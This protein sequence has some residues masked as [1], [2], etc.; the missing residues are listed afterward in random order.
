MNTQDWEDTQIHAYVDGELEAAMAQRLEADSRADA[1]LAARVARQQ[2]VRQLLR[3]QFDPVL[4][5]TVP[6]PLRA[7]A[8]RGSARSE[9]P[10]AEVIPLAAHRRPE[11]APRAAWSAREW[12]AIAATLLLGTLLG[13]TLFGTSGNLP[14]ETEQGRLV[15]SGALETA[16]STQLS[17]TAP[18]GAAQ[19]GLTFRASD[20]AWCRT[21]GLPQ[22]PAG[23]A[24][25]R[26]GHWAVQL[27][28]DSGSPARPGEFRQAGSSVSPALL[29]AIEA[30]G[31]GEALTVEQEQ[32]QV[33]AGWSFSAP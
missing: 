7:A 31:A 25:R 11:A 15:A 26:D 30:L 23:L 21:F 4:E 14:I 17:G 28:D 33:R 5:E 9:L 18:D 1:Q 8:M 12:G 27:L 29:G 20:G 32:E 16:L 19:V 22:G 6:Q 2:Q 10:R 24:C 13:A 3:A